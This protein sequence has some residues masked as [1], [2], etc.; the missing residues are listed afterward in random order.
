MT[1]LSMCILVPSVF[2]LLVAAPLSDRLRRRKPMVV[3]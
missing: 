2:A 1:V 3:L